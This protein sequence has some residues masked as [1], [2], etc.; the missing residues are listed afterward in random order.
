MTETAAAAVPS[1]STGRPRAAG[2]DSL[3][4]LAIVWMVAFHFSFDLNWFGFI[5]TDFYRSP[6]WLWQRVCIVSLFLVTAGISAAMGDHWGRT[7]RATWRRLTQVLGAGL[8]VVGGSWLAFPQSFIYFGILQGVAAMLLLHHL[9]LRRLGAW[10]LLL[11]PLAVAAPHLWASPVF[12]TRWL[13]WTGL[14]THKPITEDYVPLLPWLGPFMTGSGLGALMARRGFAALARLPALRPLAWLGRRPLTIYL[15]HQ[16]M[17]I[18]GVWGVAR[19]L[20]RAM[21]F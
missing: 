1:A 11:V 19:L 21:P 9:L 7:A 16:P 5:H 2:L 14:V 10:V 6:M 8:L 17:L 3:R 12:D 20:H 13:D 4:G 18:A 15:L